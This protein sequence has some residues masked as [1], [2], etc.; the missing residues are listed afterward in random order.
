MDRLTQQDLTPTGVKNRILGNVVQKGDPQI[1]TANVLPGDYITVQVITNSHITSTVETRTI[2]SNDITIYDGSIDPGNIVPYGDNLVASEYLFIGPWNDY[3][4]TDNLNTVTMFFLKNNTTEYTFSEHET[5]EHN[6]G[7]KISGFWD[8]SLPTFA[9]GKDI[10][11]GGDITAGIRFENVTIPRNSVILSVA[12]DLTVNF[13]SGATLDTKIYGIDQDNTADFSTD[14]TGRP[15]TT[16]F[17]DFG[18]DITTISP[19]DL[20]ST[21]GSGLVD[22]VQEIVSRDG[23]VNGNALG[24]LI[25][26]DTSA[27]GNYVGWDS[28]N[29]GD[30]NVTPAL[31]IHYN[32]ARDF[33][34]TAQS[35]SITNGGEIS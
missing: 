29:A 19:G 9:T 12:L 8:D 27:V 10:G 26:N 1:G 25:F 3:G 34:V 7:D 22:I 20:I 5:A 23:W 2:V 13:K 30:P 32:T 15:T 33:I 31:T 4:R 11:L 35:R 14:P 28:T 24:L 6:S 18:V 16:A 21:S 17:S